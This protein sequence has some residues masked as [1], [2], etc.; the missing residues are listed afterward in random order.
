MWGPPAISARVPAAAPTR[1][2]PYEIVAKIARGGMA[3]VY[4]GRARAPNGR[5]RIVA[6]KAIHHELLEDEQ[7]VTMFLD[8]AK[9]LS[10]LDHGN[11]ARTLDFGTEGNL[12]YISMEL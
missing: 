1:L 12:H 3:T 7:F 6:I 11:I 4:L 9:I 8:E 5:M 2:G 10:R